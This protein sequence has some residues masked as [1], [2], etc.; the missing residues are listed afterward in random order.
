MIVTEADTARALGSGA[1]EVLGTPRLIALCEEAAVEAIAPALPEGTTTVGVR[2]ELDHVRPT[3]VGHE[4]VAEAVVV[5]AAGRR[6]VFDVTASGPDG[7]VGSG[8]IT[9]MSVDLERFM[10]PLR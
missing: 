9:R 2:I 6:A 7:A 3:P 5:E 10:A 8:R 1:V 4:V